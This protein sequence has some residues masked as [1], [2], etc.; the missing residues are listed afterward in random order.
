[1]KLLNQLHK[2]LFY[3]STAKESY[4]FTSQDK[5]YQTLVRSIA[6]KYGLKIMHSGKKTFKLLF[7]GSTFIGNSQF[8]SF[9]CANTYIKLKY[10]EEKIDITSFETLISWSSEERKIFDKVIHIK[11]NQFLSFLQ[12]E[13][14]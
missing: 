13:V 2:A 6:E 4:I 9:L 5:E 11:L 8:E 14:N 12:T 3:K 10:D 7:P 1:M